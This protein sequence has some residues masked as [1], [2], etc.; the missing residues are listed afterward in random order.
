MAWVWESDVYPVSSTALSVGL[1][2]IMQL[3]QILLKV[4]FGDTFCTIENF[5][6]YCLSFCVILFPSFLNFLDHILRL[7][8]V[9]AFD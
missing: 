2:C 6:L 9:L 5:L 8:F 3:N 4:N 7:K 1:I